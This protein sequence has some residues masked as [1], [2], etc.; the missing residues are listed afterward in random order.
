MSVYCYNK[1]TLRAASYSACVVYTKTITHHY[2]PPFQWII[3]NYYMACFCSR[4]IARSDWLILGHHSSVMPTSRLQ[5]GKNKVKRHIINNVL[6]A[7]VRSSRVNLEH[8]EHCNFS[9]NFDSRLQTVLKLFL[10]VDCSRQQQQHTTN[11]PISMGNNK[12]FLVQFW[13]NL[14]EWVFL[15]E[16]RADSASAISAF[17]KKSKCKWI[18][19]WT[20]K[21][22]LLLINIIM[23]KF[24]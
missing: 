11:Q 1:V 5:D 3:V 9:S 6:T 23:K 16:A 22:V 10:W 2:S 21:T 13:N 8:Y 19:G 12:V 15:Y 17:L 4:Y 18:P 20:R 24:A 7:H 14:H